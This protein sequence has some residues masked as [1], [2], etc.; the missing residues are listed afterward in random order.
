MTV[1]DAP[2]W[3]TYMAWVQE[4]FGRL[5]PS[6]GTFDEMSGRLLEMWN[7]EPAWNGTAFGKIPSVFEEPNAPLVWIVDGDSEEAVNRDVPRT[8]LDWIWGSS[9]VILPGVSHFAFLQDPRT[10]NAMLDRF[11]SIER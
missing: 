4:D 8:M 11:L 2:T 3:K 10:F 6:T 5:S 7:S 9:L 1:N